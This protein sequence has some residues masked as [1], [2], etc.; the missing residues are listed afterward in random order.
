M[1]ALSGRFAF[2]V[3]LALTTACGSF[4]SRLN[5]P[6]EAATGP[7]IVRVVGSRRVS[8]STLAP[9]REVCRAP[10][11]ASV[12]PARG[13]FV[14]TVEGLP[15][16]PPF[17]VSSGPVD[18]VVH[19][20]APVLPGLAAVIGTVG[21]A[22]MG[23]GLAALAADLGGVHSFDGAAL[24]GGLTALGGSALVSVALTMWL[25]TGTHVIVEPRGT[26]APV[27]TR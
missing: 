12:D 8:L 23:V 26:P 13:P 1:H 9:R 10:C 21:V 25:L 24:A 18:V 6:S 20:A 3:T 17:D 14:A 22:G 2:A 5:A 16:S 15:D 19:H 27:A 4:E 7:T 11:E